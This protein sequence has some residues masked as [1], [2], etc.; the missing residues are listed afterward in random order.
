MP[1]LS[2][3]P[4]I[5]QQYLKGLWNKDRDHFWRIYNELLR[6]KNIHVQ[7]EENPA[8]ISHDKA[9]PRGG[10]VVDIRAQRGLLELNP[11]PRP[12][13]EEFVEQSQVKALELLRVFKLPIKAYEVM[14][15]ARV[16]ASKHTFELP[17]L[18][19]FLEALLE[20]HPIKAEGLTRE[21][22]LLLLHLGCWVGLKRGYHPITGEVS[23]H[24]PQTLLGAYL[25][26]NKQPETQRKSLK[27]ALDK[28]AA[29]GFVSYMGRMGNAKK[30]EVLPDGTKKEVG[31][32]PDGTVFN[33]R[34]RPGRVRPLNRDDLAL[35][36]WRD[37]DSDIRSG[38]TVN[39][40][41]SSRMS[42]SEKAVDRLVSEQEL[43][44]WA[45][46]PVLKASRSLTE[47]DIHPDRVHALLRNTIQDVKFSTNS[48]RMQ[49]IGA[50]AG[51]ISKNLMDEHSRWMYF[52]LLGGAR[53]LLERGVNR[54]D[55]LQAHIGQVLYEY[56]AGQA[57]K[58]G[59]VL[60]TRLKESGL[61]EELSRAWEGCT[62]K[63][64]APPDGQPPGGEA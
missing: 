3:F 19:P 37:L 53:V 6:S 40:L 39:R 21:V 56:G 22:A 1:D 57:H 23:F 13:W 43:K 54:F 47:W 16:V 52:K 2:I 36:D 4:L 38:R 61:W 8:S 55:Q 25:W 49:F 64:K 11:P 50:A 45:L 14:Q 41:L 26:P 42:H 24:I 32:M 62:W 51:A 15:T 59:A 58:P 46:P 31:W 35:E 7:D 28:L 17:S 10:P 27:R 33:V 63:H 30:Y 48:T 18:K 20:T 44:E 9:P 60:I 34:L 12:Q 29:Q 5:H